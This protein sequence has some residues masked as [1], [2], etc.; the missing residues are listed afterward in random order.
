MM[1][2]AQHKCKKK[3]NTIIY[4]DADKTYT[5]HEQI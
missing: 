4:G 1:N 5:I 3:M 2:T